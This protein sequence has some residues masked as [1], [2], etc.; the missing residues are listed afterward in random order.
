MTPPGDANSKPL[1]DGHASRVWVGSSALFG[2]AA[3]GLGAFG[4]HGLRTIVTSDMLAVWRTG[5][6]YQMFHT[7]AML[8]LALAPAHAVSALR[9]WSLRLWAIGICLFS[10][11]L[12]AMV[13]SGSRVLGIITPIGGLCF[14]AGWLLLVCAAWTRPRASIRR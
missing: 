12:Y 4:S 5:V 7:L 11:S 9:R 3:V 1:A 8:V 2:L 14:M 6:E 10:G 13:L